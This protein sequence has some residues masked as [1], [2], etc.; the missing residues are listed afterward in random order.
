M[1]YVPQY[2]YDLFVSYAHLDEETSDGRAGWVSQFAGELKIA[3]SR[4]L[5]E[6]AALWL[7]RERL[8]GG[9]RLSEKVRYDLSRT[10]VLLRLESPSFWE[11]GYCDAETD[12]FTEAVPRLDAQLLAGRSRLIRAAIMPTPGVA[13]SDEMVIRLHHGGKP[14]AVDV[15]AARIAPDIASI[16]REMEASR[17][18][19]Y[20]PRPSVEDAESDAAWASTIGELKAL[21]YRRTPRSFAAETE[22]DIRD[23]I[24]S[25][26]LVVLVIG[27]NAFRRDPLKRIG[28]AIKVAVPSSSGS[29][30]GPVTT[31]RRNRA[32]CSSLCAPALGR[33]NFSRK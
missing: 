28:V 4:A 25:A 2:V 15:A 5:G 8:T 21:N 7:D 29:R 16:L 31:P 19:I 32:G 30:L 17:A 13:D 9:F 14:L 6:K 3:L 27:A 23:A 33:T 20:I 12:W 1:A 26:R 11:S 18:P 22:T 24:G 10:S